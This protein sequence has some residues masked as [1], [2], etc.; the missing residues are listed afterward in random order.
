MIAIPYRS[1]DKPIKNS[2][3][4]SIIKTLFLSYYYYISIKKYEIDILIYNYILNNYSVFKKFFRKSIEELTIDFINEVLT[5]LHIKEHFF[6]L[7]F[8]EIFHKIKLP[9]QEL[10]IK[11]S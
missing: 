5:V 10:K 2:S 8:N 7:F 11:A 4:T 3:F 9:I 6:D 1:K